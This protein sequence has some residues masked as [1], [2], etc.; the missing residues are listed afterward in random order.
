MSALDI[1]GLFDEDGHEIVK[2]NKQDDTDD[3]L[4]SISVEQLD[5][6]TPLS[7]GRGLNIT[8]IEDD[9]DDVPPPTSESNAQDILRS[10]GKVPE[11]FQLVPQVPTGDAPEDYLPKLKRIDA[12]TSTVSEQTEA[13][14][15]YDKTRELAKLFDD[16]PDL[17]ILGVDEFVEKS[18]PK[19][20]QGVVR[21]LGKATNEDLESLAVAV[22]SVEDTAVNLGAALTMGL[23]KVGVDMG[24]GDDRKAGEKFAGDLSMLLEMTE[25]TVPGAGALFSPV[26]RTFKEAKKIAKEKAR[27]EAFKARRMNINKAKEATLEQRQAKE[28][29][30]KEVADNNDNIRQTLIDEFE[31]E[32]DVIIS[33]RVGDKK[34]LDGEKAREA[35]LEKAREIQFTK[36]G[37]DFGGESG[38]VDVAADDMSRLLFEMRG[39]ADEMVSPIIKPE[40]LDG[41]VAAVAD[42]KQIAKEKNLDVFKP[43]KYSNGKDYQLIDHLFDMTVSKDLVE[44]DE[45]VGILNKYNVSFE[46]YILT[47][48]GSGSQAGKVLQKL[49]QIKRMRPANEMAEMR[50]VATQQRQNVFRETF[51]RLEGIR[52][53]GL[54]S[55]LATAARN[56]TS[57]GI[58]APLDT[59]ANVM[60]TALYNAGEAEGV[61]GA[62][63]AFTKS[64]IQ[65]ENWADSYRHMRYMFGP[66]SRFDAKDYV[67]FILDRPELAQ[68][69]DLMFNQLNELQKTTGRGR[70]AREQV[71]RLLKE[72]RDKAK[73]TKTK[74]NER[75]ARKEAEAEARRLLSGTGGEKFGKVVDGI[76]SEGE[77]AVSVLNSANRWQEYLVRRGSFLGEL[78][79][80]VKREYKIDLIDALNDGKIL[81]LLNDAP[82]IKPKNARSFTELA[83][84]ATTKALDVTYA[85]QPETKMFREITS[86]ITR[87]GLTVAIPF[88]RFMFNSL[89]LMGNYAGG[90]SIPLYKKIMGQIPKGTK[91]SAKDRQRISRNFVG[92]AAALAAYQARTTEDADADYKLLSVGD[93]TVMDTTPQF[94]LR[95]YMYIGESIKHLRQGTFKD[96]FFNK[97]NYK[98]FSETFLGTNIRTGVGSGIVEEVFNMAQAASGDGSGDIAKDEANAKAFGRLYG[99]YLSTWAVP[100]AQ[101]IDAQRAIGVRGETYKETGVDPTLDPEEAKKQAADRPFIARGLM[102]RDVRKNA[103]GSINEIDADLDLNK[104]GVISEDELPVR[105]SLFQENPSRV[106][107]AY[108]V[109]LGLSLKTKDPAD[110]QYM[111]S[112]GITEFEAGSQS[113]VPSIRNFQNKQLRDLILPTVVSNARAF[114]EEQR[115]RYKTESKVIKDEMSE[116][117]Y[118]R[119][120]VRTYMQEQMKHYRATFKDNAKLMADAPAYIDNYMKFVRIPPAIRKEAAKEFM[121]L[122]D[123]KPNGG[124]LYDIIRLMEYAKDIKRRYRQG[125]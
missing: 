3:A 95:Q 102:A 84:D 14:F 15:N 93:G 113:R 10:T 66:E 40:K 125:G 63:K 71:D 101:I 106:G 22:Q 30:A 73:R 43:K 64:L 67:D 51:M 91:L 4:E 47:V 29:L 55:Q 18:V 68:Q 81:D 34:V 44:G 82:S 33:T 42:L 121:S 32:N 85:K 124:D 38:G 35:G 11:G 90:A 77:D 13:V 72:A 19:P 52:R 16:N 70:P 24:F 2:T 58:R 75:Q 46:D 20:L 5:D 8:G 6:S 99:E 12:P 1:T 60:D 98:E 79:R 114:E 89:E 62:T 116:E 41:L 120:S 86:F 27:G 57:A 83:A 100:A 96:F 104:D 7:N 118:V 21:F 109:G 39:Q 28:T 37:T 119:Q 112:F 110:G 88:P 108:K 49:S 115:D 65:R 61:A 78:E 117:L 50:R 36:T 92:I 105:E 74:F 56:V 48:V 76:L 80:L 31:K 23:E 111:K 17:D 69:Y 122:E 107:S 53:G 94:P 87:N 97:N 25:A 123:R 45:L 59:L 26:R 54:V 103:D 9:E